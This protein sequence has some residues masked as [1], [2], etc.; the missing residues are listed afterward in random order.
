MSMHISLG[1]QMED[2]IRAKVAGGMYTNNTEVIRDAVRRMQAEEARLAAWQAAIK[3]GDDQLL[4]GQGRAYT[5]ELLDE[6]SERARK[7]MG[8]G[9]AL[10]PNALP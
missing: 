4:A 5:P 2:F 10:N 1:N 9:K 6:I 8:T 3:A 7:A